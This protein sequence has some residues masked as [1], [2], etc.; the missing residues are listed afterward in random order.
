[1][2]DY[3]FLWIVRDGGGGVGGGGELAT[4]ESFAHNMKYVQVENSLMN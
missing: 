4:W 2:D 1:M 3:I